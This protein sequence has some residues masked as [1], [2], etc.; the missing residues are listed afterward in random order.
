[1]SFPADQF[2]SD[3]FEILMDDTFHAV[4]KAGLQIQLTPTSLY[5]TNK[6]IFLK[7]RVEIEMIRQISI[8]DISKFNNTIINDCPTLDIICEKSD[9]RIYIFIP[10]EKRKEVFTNILKTLHSK[11]IESQEACNKY[12]ILLRHKIQEFQSLQDFCSNGDY[13]ELSQIEQRNKA[14]VNIVKYHLRFLNLFDFLADLTEASPFLLF[15]FLFFSI[16][17]LS[18]IFEHY[19]FGG[20]VCCAF[21]LL[22][23]R[24][25][26]FKLTDNSPKP[27]EE[28]HFEGIDEEI[29][30]LIESTK[31]FQ[32][33]IDK[34]LRWKNPTASF[35]VA[36]FAFILLLM[37]I[38]LDPV[39]LLIVSIFL[40]A[41]FERW[42]PLNIGS[43][44]NILSRL[45]FW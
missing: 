10:D 36:L 39:F 13:D 17:V 19:S 45:I 41:F 29:R 1:M 44:P 23:I 16:V 5:L 30:P 42:D 28:E 15:S 40:L 20:F 43:L 8:K 7:P 6:H 37:F 3:E 4:G 21:L 31:K 22:L 24:N 33:S 14:T 35:E 38:F 11:V 34:R 32:Q 25:A 9:Q 27:K 12:A 26:L 2:E 18:L